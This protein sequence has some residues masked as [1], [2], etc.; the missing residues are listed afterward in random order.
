MS[1]MGLLRA[2]LGNA[3]SAFWWAAKL[4][5]LVALYASLFTIP[6]PQSGVGKGQGICTNTEAQSVCNCVRKPPSHRSLSM[7]QDALK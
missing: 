2:Q 1:G 5:G 3:N 7:P 4:I 6:R